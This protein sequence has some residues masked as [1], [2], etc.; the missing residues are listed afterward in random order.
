MK[1]DLAGT[2]FKLL[3]AM[4]HA[5]GVRGAPSS[6][7]KGRPA[8]NKHMAENHRY[9]VVRVTAE[10]GSRGMAVSC[11]KGSEAAS[12]SFNRITKAH[13]WR[14]SRNHGKKSIRFRIMEVPLDV[15]VGCELAMPPYG[16][17]FPDNYHKATEV[18][19]GR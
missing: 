19:D 1:K 15:E 17:G 7:V 6:G 5:M 4:A 10:D 12:G 13:H 3:P 9:A 8:I 14:D 11:H 2:G 18:N 16:G